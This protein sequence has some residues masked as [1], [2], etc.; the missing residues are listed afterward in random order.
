M[1][2]VAC[3]SWTTRLK[4]HPRCVPGLACN[5]Q[6]SSHAHSLQ[7]YGLTTCGR[8]ASWPW[9][10]VPY[11]SG[12]GFMVQGGYNT[13]RQSR[14]KAKRTSVTTDVLRRA[15]GPV[16]AAAGWQCRAGQG[17]R[18]ATSAAVKLSS[19]VSVATCTLLL[20]LTIASGLRKDASV[21]LWYCSMTS[22]SRTSAAR[23]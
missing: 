15:L 9:L 6:V 21:S 20:L 5:L 18:H 17:S 12:A 23:R 2:P 3:G 1:P 13:D 19:W 11:S 10:P 16:G 14:C 22:C 4:A 7:P 8:C